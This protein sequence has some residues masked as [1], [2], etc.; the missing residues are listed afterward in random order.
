MAL[1]RDEETIPLFRLRVRAAHHLLQSML[2]V[3]FFLY[4][5]DVRVRTTYL[6]TEMIVALNKLLSN[7]PFD[8][9]EDVL[10]RIHDE[11]ILIMN[12]LSWR[13]HCASV[14]M[15]NLLVALHDLGGDY[16]LPE[17]HLGKLFHMTRQGLG[18]LDAT[19]LN[20]F[21]MTTLLYYAGGRP[22]YSSLVDAI[23]KSAISR[24]RTEEDPFVAAELTC[25]F[26]D[27]LG[28]PFFPITAKEE[29]VR[30]TMVKRHMQVGPAD[31]AEVVQFLGA[32]SW[33]FSWEAASDLGAVLE[34]KELRSP[35]EC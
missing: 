19:E 12:S 34:K 29:L 8:L 20:Y 27:L 23:A 21:Q 1:C 18:G 26:F 17:K 6:A 32:R 30:I 2:D 10:K 24:F 33:F 14:E 13:D 22:R 7:C 15:L 28:C 5:M 16:L 4:A 3:I 11:S 31:V 9:R 35:Y 25:L